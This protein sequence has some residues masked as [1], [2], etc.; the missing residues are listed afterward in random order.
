MPFEKVTMA[1]LPFMIPLLGVWIALTY[2]PGLTLWLPNL[3]LG[4]E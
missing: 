2:I 3:V 1:C 4:P